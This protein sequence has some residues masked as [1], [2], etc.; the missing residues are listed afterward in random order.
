MSVRSV[1]TLRTVF[2]ICGVYKKKTLIFRVYI[3]NNAYI[4]GLKGD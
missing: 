1:I 4:C 3:G 2:L